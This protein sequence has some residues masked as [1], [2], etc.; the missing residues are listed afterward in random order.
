VARFQAGPDDDEVITVADDDVRLL[1]DI[2]PDEAARPYLPAMAK[3]WLLPLY[4]PFTRAIG[5]RRLHQRVVDAAGIGPGDRVLDLGCGTANLSF[6]IL[7]A[8]PTAQVTGVD[9]DPKALRRAASKARRRHVPLTLVRGFADRLALP[10]A[11]VDHVVS[12]L[13]LHHV[14]TEDK[15]GA[16][17]EIARVLRPGG[18]VTILDFGVAPR[19]AGHMNRVGHIHDNADGG[20][21]RLL[22][23]AGLVDARESAAG[24]I[25]R[26]P[27]LLVQARKA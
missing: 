9:P 5:A 22:A 4:D 7:R 24:S 17:A 16:A 1:D 13:V 14:E 20:I 10:D 25:M 11:S 3:D 19:R 21:P 23:S 8:V 12:S 2:G 15:P 26:T 6:A 18:K 27:L